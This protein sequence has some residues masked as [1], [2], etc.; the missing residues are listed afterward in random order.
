MPRSG[1]RANLVVA[2]II[3]LL[4]GLICTLFGYRRWSQLW[5]ATQ[6]RTNNSQQA[7]SP[8][9]SQNRPRLT[10]TNDVGATSAPVGDLSSESAPASRNDADAKS[11]SKERPACRIES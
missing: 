11:A 8:A 10:T 3:L 4:T 9:G 5:P 7:P 6:V 1:N 2:G